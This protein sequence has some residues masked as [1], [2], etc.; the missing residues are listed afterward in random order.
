MRKSPCTRKQNVKKVKNMRTKTVLLSALLG[1]LG[2]VSVMAQTNVYSQ[3]AV[4]YIN[5][6]C[7]P[8]Y[9]II[10]CP[11]IGSPDNTLNT[12]L[13]NSSG[14]YNGDALYFY[15]TSSGYTINE[16]VPAF[17]SPDGSGWSLGSSTNFGSCINPGQGVFF[18]SAPSTNVTLTFVGTVPSGPVT[19]TLNVGYNLVSSI[20]P[21]SGDLYSNGVSQFNN[22][23][24]GDTIYV[25]TG[26]SQQYTEIY[27]TLP[28]FITGSTNL[29]PNPPGDPTLSYVAE[30]FFYFSASAPIGWVENFSV[31]Q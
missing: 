19:N 6:T 29:W 5:I 16:A 10:S 28:S 31:A 9:N 25:Y 13:N 14:A 27:S 26:A 22:S 24:P 11:L 1:A 30:G 21:M 17:L 20:V 4:G 3:N 23:N 18:F 2:S 8:T 12:L 15:S 7:Y